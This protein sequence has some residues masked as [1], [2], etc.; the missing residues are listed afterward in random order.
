MCNTEER[1]LAARTF[2]NDHCESE[3]SPVS[4]CAKAVPGRN[5]TSDLL[6]SMPAHHKPFLRYEYE[7]LEKPS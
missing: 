5:A 3:Q 7:S 6:V 1:S 2:S 4:S